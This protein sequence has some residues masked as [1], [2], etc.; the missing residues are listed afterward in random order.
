[1]RQ[2]SVHGRSQLR[3]G[4][5]PK[6]PGSERPRKR[7]PMPTWPTRPLPSVPG[8]RSRGGRACLRPA[9]HPGPPRRPIELRSILGASSVSHRNFSGTD[10]ARP[11]REAWPTRPAGRA[12]AEVARRTG[13]GGDADVDS[14]PDLTA[15]IA[16]HGVPVRLLPRG[17]R[18]A[19]L[20]STRRPARAQPES[21]TSPPGKGG[22]SAPWLVTIARNLV[23]DHFKSGRY[24]LEVSTGDGARRCGSGRSCS[25]RAARSWPWLTTSPTSALL[26]G[27]CASSTREQQEPCVRSCTAS[28]SAGRRRQ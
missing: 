18:S 25:P 7:T 3:P 1:M 2:T 17:H 15:D 12:T 27:G 9:N 24:R 28:R 14:E 6:Q 19:R 16:R 10:A 21:A 4:Q 8:C 26:G 23:T 5:C 13:P 20:K 11:R 22:T